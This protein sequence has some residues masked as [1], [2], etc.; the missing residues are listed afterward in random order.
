MGCCVFG[1]LQET[2][3]GSITGGPPGERKRKEQ[4]GSSEAQKG[5]MTCPRLH[6]RESWELKA[7]L[8][9]NPVLF[10]LDNSSHGLPMGR[11]HIPS[12]RIL[13]RRPY[14]AAADFQLTHNFQAPN[15]KCPTYGED[16]GLKK[17]ISYHV[18]EWDFCKNETAYNI[19]RNCYRNP[20]SQLNC[21]S[22][23]IYCPYFIFFLQFTLGVPLF[24]FFYSIL[25][26][27]LHFIFYFPLLCPILTPDL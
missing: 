15:S 9:I 27:I 16:R 26:S 7:S 3:N 21:W 2:Q 10:W 19:D 5:K 25:F 11:K 6:S 12:I 14:L 23:M 18:G 1:H 8:L 22:T 4:V 20:P 24:Y 13:S 17:F